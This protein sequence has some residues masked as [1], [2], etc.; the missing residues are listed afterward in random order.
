MPLMPV[1]LVFAA[2]DSSLLPF[3]AS[4]LRGA[5]DF[6]LPSTA[7]CD[8]GVL[9]GPPAAVVSS[10]ESIWP[11]WAPRWRAKLDSSIQ[12]F[13][14]KVEPKLQPLLRPLYPSHVLNTGV[15]CLA[16]AYLPLL[17]QY[18]PQEDLGDDDEDYDYDGKPKDRTPPPPPDL[19]KPAFSAL[20]MTLRELSVQVIRKAVERA[21]IPLVD[22]RTGWELTKDTFK[23]AKRKAQ[24][25]LES[26]SEAP[27]LVGDIFVETLKGHILGTVASLL[28]QLFMDVVDFTK[29]F[30]RHRRAIYRKPRLL[31]SQVVRLQRRMLAQGAKSVGALVASSACAAAGCLLWHHGGYSVGFALGDMLGVSAVNKF[32][33][34]FIVRIQKEMLE[35][36]LQSIRE[37]KQGE[38]EER[39]KKEDAE[40]K[41]KGKE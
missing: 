19:V 13:E 7:H 24:R 4:G 9:P 22:K 14:E 15:R 39:K 10:P 26:W 11:Q 12:E 31:Y 30:Y 17:E 35:L 37:E 3:A 5:A 8:A 38:E 36:E 33:D 23:S 41:G 32:V 27:G 21:V 2:K 40:L 16:L 34:P 18:L 28:L 25:K 1:S 29:Y 20:R 6:I